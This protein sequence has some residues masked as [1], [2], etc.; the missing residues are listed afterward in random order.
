MNCLLVAQGQTTAA[1]QTAKISPYGPSVS[2]VAAGE[3]GSPIQYDPETYTIN[4][5]TNSVGGWYLNVDSN[6]NGIYSAVIN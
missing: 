2:G 4:G 6:D 5:I 1:V 3:A